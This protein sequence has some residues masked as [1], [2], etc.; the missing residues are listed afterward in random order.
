MLNYV[1]MTVL[2]HFQR[3][4]HGRFSED[5]S[6]TLPLPALIGESAKI[7][8]ADPDCD[9]HASWLKGE[10]FLGNMAVS[11]KATV[12]HFGTTHHF[13]SGHVICRRVIRA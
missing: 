5:P 13:P 6:K 8:H 9:D 7:V 12:K 2:T 10:P 4:S 3:A 1:S 11:A